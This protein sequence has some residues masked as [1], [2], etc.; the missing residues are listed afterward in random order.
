M[1]GRVLLVTWDGGGCAVPAYH[2]GSRLHD[3]GHEVHL[4]G[5]VDQEQASRDAGLQFAAFESVPAWPAGLA[6][7]DAIDRIFDYLTAPS[8]TEEIIATVQ[9]VR[10]DLVVVDGMMSA[11][12]T[13]LDQIEVA[14]AALCHVRYSEFTGPWGTRVMGRPVAE[15]FDRVD[16]VLALTPPGFDAPA[17][18]ADNVLFVGAITAPER[19][20]RERLLADAGL[21]FLPHRDRPSVLV[22]LST[23]NQNQ[24]KTLPALLDAMQGLSAHVVL[25]LGG[26]IDPASV[27]APANVSVRGFVPHEA[28]LPFV[29]VFVTHAG[30]S[31][32]TTA[33]AFGVP[34]VCVPQGRD[35]FMNA[36]LVAERGV[37]VDLGQE[38]SPEQ[39]ESAVLEVLGTPTYTAAA[40]RFADPVAGARATEAIAGLLRH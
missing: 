28:V 25:T 30:L 29:D 35:Q 9:R 39:V 8:T 13:A 17:P 2:L 5:W 36:E 26:V 7:D 11:A 31:G 15:L 38:P 33:L 27:V 18:R 37:G 12:F 34:M 40:R 4:L 1:S 22:A 21:E 6:Q 14:S 10:P 20:A 32:V 16:L 3:L 24:A 23:T 19:V